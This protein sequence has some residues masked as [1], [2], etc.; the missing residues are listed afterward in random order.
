MFAY[1]ELAEYGKLSDTLNSLHE[2]FQTRR[3]ELRRLI[4]QTAERRMEALQVLAKA[5]RITRHLT[6]RQRHICGITYYLGDIKAR[7]VQSSGETLPLIQED[8]TNHFPQAKELIQNSQGQNIMVI[9]RMIENVKKNLLHLDLLELRCREILVSIKKALEAFQHEWNNIRRKF[10]PFG[11]F[12]S[13]VRFLRRLWG[14]SYFS[15]R[16]M[17]DVAALG[18]ITTM[19]LKIADTPLV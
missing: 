9:I 18:N 14:N 12:S 16:D 1:N 4:E 7:I 2:K 8:N 6:G 19:V 17:D 10:F 13:I 15:F 5:N 3:L 11:I